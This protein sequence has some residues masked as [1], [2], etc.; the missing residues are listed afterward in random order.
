MNENPY[1]KTVRNN[2]ARYKIINH[3]IHYSGA[4]SQTSYNIP[5]DFFKDFISNGI[6]EHDHDL[7]YSST[8]SEGEE[9]TLYACTLKCNFKLGPGVLWLI[10]DEYNNDDNKL[11]LVY[12]RKDGIE[13]SKENKS[14]WRTK[15]Q[16]RPAKYREWGEG[17]EW[18]VKLFDKNISGNKYFFDFDRDNGII[19]FDVLFNSIKSSLS[20]YDI[21]STYYSDDDYPLNWIFFGAP[22]TGKSYIL[23]KIKTNFIKHD[24]DYERVTFHPDY[25]YA[26]FVGSYKPVSNYYEENSDEKENENPISYKF[27]P[28]PFIRVLVDS[29]KDESNNPHLLIIEE[30]NRSNVAAVFG[31]VFQLLDRK[32]GISE[33]PIKASEDL[34]KHLKLVF[35]EDYEIN[36]P[37]DEIII[38]NNMYIWATMNSA[39]QGVYML[40]TAFKRRW[41]FSYIGINHFYE[42][43]CDV[44]VLLGNNDKPIKWNT[45]REAI[46]EQLLSFNVNE[47]KLLGPFFISPKFLPNKKDWDKYNEDK[48][49]FEEN[50]DK[51]FNKNDKFKEIFK[52]KVLMYLFEDVAKHR[53]KDLF[54][55]GNKEYLLYSDLYKRFDEEGINIFCETIIKKLNTDH[56]G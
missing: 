19:T 13:Y 52:N 46:N 38:P 21:E 27:V 32:D 37:N 4:A 36:F 15:P 25:S 22:G 3:E 42:K 53:R 8:T 11:T 1:M 33:Y 14:D 9:F 54:D 20:I 34:K 44:E 31:D 51:F 43:I 5:I 49:K 47:D 50:G 2:E 28:G 48:E 12:A 30:I 45:L 26:N 24:K 18:F 41:N 56:K 17:Y 16:M 6:L 35:K 10:G 40:D 23:N 29:I 55:K 39:D 7:D